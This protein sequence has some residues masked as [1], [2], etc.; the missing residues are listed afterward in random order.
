LRANEFSHFDK[1]AKMVAG[2][3]CGKSYAIEQR[4][5]PERGNCLVQGSRPE[6]EPPSTKRQGAAV[7]EDDCA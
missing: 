4:S 3:G 5:D 7:S 2:C 6:N 1:A